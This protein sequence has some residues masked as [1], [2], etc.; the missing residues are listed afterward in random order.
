RE[1]T[2]KAFAHCGVALPER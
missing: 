2:E 1:A